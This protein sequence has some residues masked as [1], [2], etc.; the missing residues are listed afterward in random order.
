MLKLTLPLAALAAVLLASSAQA[1]VEDDG[2]EWN[3]SPG[4]GN[5]TPFGAPAPEMGGWPFIVMAGAALIYKRRR[6]PK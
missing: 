5:G 4:G 6:A 1:R 3:C 2:C